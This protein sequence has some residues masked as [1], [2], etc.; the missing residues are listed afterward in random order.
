MAATTA[1]SSTPGTSPSPG[2]SD[3]GT[4]TNAGSIIETAFNAGFVGLVGSFVNTGTISL[5]PGTSL[6]FSVGP[7]TNLGTIDLAAN[8]DLIAESFIQMVGATTSIGVNGTTN[9]VGQINVV[10]AATPGGT[11]DIAT[12]TAP[13]VGQLFQPFT[14]GSVTGQ[15][16]HVNGAV[17]GDGLAYSTAYSATNLRAQRGHVVSPPIAGGVGRGGPDQHAG[18]ARTGPDLVLHRHQ[19]RYGGRHRRLGRLGVPRHR[20]HLQPGGPSCSN[21][22]ARPP[23]SSRAPAAPVAS[24]PP[25]R[26]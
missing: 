19:Q 7:V 5:A 4:Y 8:A 21:A 11:L 17:L 2:I 23:P 22:S 25:C 14:W 12:A 9:Q 24:P 18:R 10:G 16:P 20:D 1:P 15:F 6:K 26:R 13:T 3:T